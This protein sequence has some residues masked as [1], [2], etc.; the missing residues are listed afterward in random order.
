MIGRGHVNPP[1]LY[2][3][4]EA[5]KA[6]VLWQEVIIV[7]WT[8]LREGALLET[9]RDPFRGLSEKLGSEIGWGH[10][11]GRVKFET[12]D[13]RGDTT[14]TLLFEGKTSQAGKVRHVQRKN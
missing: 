7:L 9:G 5:I 10:P 4:V 12:P 13:W 3:H 11:Y 1:R 8:K 2:W 6:R 14:V